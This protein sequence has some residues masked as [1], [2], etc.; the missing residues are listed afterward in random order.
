MVSRGSNCQNPSSTS[1]HCNV[2]AFFWEHTITL[3]PLSLWI[4]TDRS[5]H[6]SIWTYNFKNW[7]NWQER[8]HGHTNQAK[9]PVERI[10]TFLFEL[11][12]LK[13]GLIYKLMDME[14]QPKPSYNANFQC[15]EQE[16]TVYNHFFKIQTWVCVCVSRFIWK[17][18]SYKTD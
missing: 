2:E 12:L 6:F 15:L 8:W 4:P 10:C 9:L 14:T 11:T 3:S 1:V 13:N 5:M 7:S 17:S 18:I 16:V